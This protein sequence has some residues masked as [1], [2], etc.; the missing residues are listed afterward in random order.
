MKTVRGHYDGSVVILDEPAPVSGE[1]EVMVQFPELTSADA[2]EM[3]DTR[4]YWESAEAIATR[5]RT[6]ASDGLLRPPGTSDVPPSG[7]PEQMPTDEEWAARA[8]RISR[9]LIRWAPEAPSDDLATVEEIRTGL[10]E[11]PVQFAGTQDE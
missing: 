11:H 8:A 6:T 2:P 7:L 4:Q 9:S 5:F 10:R 3:L 1:V